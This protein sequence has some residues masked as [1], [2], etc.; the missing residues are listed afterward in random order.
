MKKMNKLTIAII[1]AVVLVVASSA[2]AYAVSTPEVTSS[3]RCSMTL[4]WGILQR[5][6]PRLNS[7]LSSC[8]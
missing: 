8:A 4:G 1:L 7:F 2:I 5:M 3:A 6:F